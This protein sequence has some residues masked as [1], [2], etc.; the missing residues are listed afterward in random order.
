MPKIILER[1]FADSSHKPKLRSSRLPFLHKSLAQSL[2]V[3]AMYGLIAFLSGLPDFGSLNKVATAQSNTVLRYGFISA[4]GKTP[5]G[6]DGWALQKG[7][8]TSMLQETGFSEV[9]V[10]PFPNGP[11]LNEALSAGALDI[12]TYG[13]TPAIVAKAAGIDTRAIRQT[14]VGMNVW[15]VGQKGD[16]TTLDQLAGQTVATQLGSYMHR[17]LIGL[18]SESDLL[19]KVT[20][21][22]LLSKDAQPALERGDIAAYAAPVGFGPLLISQ[23][24]PVIDQAADHPPLRGTS[25]TVATVAFLKDHPDFP[26][27]WNQAIEE[28]VKD[29]KAT[30][31]AYY[32][33]HAKAVGF[34]VEVIRDSYPVDEFPVEAFSPEGLS[35]LEGAKAFLVSQQL[36]KSDFNISDWLLKA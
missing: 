27:L 14:H 34:P 17:Y 25:I 36:A 12:G 1:I 33:F 3:L 28:S 6:P 11:N 35:L 32:Q 29:L 31:E 22:P 30:P 26:Q 24:F 15:L 21:V 16:P 20:I 18:L 19:K 10:F 2:V 23:G 9:E 13:D 5:V 8:L 4:A 7:I